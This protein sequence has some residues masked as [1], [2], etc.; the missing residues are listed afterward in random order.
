MKT[1]QGSFGGSGLLCCIELYIFHVR[2]SVFL[3]L[4]TSR[5]ILQSVILSLSLVT[6][7]FNYD[8]IFKDMMWHNLDV[9]AIKSQPVIQPTYQVKMQSEIINVKFFFA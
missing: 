9:N 8:V 2:L 1:G 7:T 4:S 6:S 3:K 5:S